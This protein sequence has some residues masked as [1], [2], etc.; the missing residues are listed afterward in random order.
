M[1]GS[2][3]AGGGEGE[4]G[5]AGARWPP[6]LLSGPQMLNSVSPTG[7]QVTEL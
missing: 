4:G 5:G 3:L 6:H 2:N 7:P 1:Q